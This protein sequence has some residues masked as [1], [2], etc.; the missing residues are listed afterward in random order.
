MTLNLKSGRWWD[1]ISQEL[2]AAAGSLGVSLDPSGLTLAYLQKGLTGLELKNLATL[3]RPEGGLAA[4]A[5]PLQELLS[6]WGLQNCPVSLAVSGELG[7]FRPAVLPKAAGENLAQVVAYELDRFLPLPAETLYYDY[8]VLKETDPEIHL[9]LMA[10]PRGPVAE[11][12]SLLGQAGLQPLSLEP[13]PVAAA[14]AFAR[15]GRRLPASWLLVQA[16]SGHLEL[17]QIRGRTFS[18]LPPLSLKTPKDLG[19]A[20]AGELERLRGE[21]A[22]PEALCL[23]GQGWAR[24]DPETVGK[25]L[26]VPLFTPAGLALKGW[27]AAEEATGAVLPALGAA[28]KG[29]GKVPLKTNLLPAAEQAKVKLTGFSLSK[30]LLLSLLG[31]LLLWGGSLMIHKRVTL[32]QVNRQLAALAPEAQRVEEQLKETQVLSRQLQSFQRRLEQ[33]PNKLRILRDLTQLIPEHTWLFHLRL[34]QQNL[35]M[36]GV[37][38]S[39]ADLIPLLERSG[40]LTNTEFASPIV[41]D[42][43]KLEHFKIKAEIKGV[44]L[45]S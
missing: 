40:W 33:S 29:L 38:R 4:L 26:G 19:P 17:S 12:L 24:L 8:Q 7:F 6:R 27:T 25:R 11:C 44:E 5:E 36:S 14:N 2:H 28:L 37:S 30:F 43:S 20:L 13:A 15:L 22:A 42:A 10:L 16:A 9:L 1:L 34:A 32:Y 21:G 41:T 3:A 35:E 45:G 23:Y 31:L 18:T 39:A